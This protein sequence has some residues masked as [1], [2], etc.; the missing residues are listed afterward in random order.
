LWGC[1]FNILRYR[2]DSTANSPLAA[3]SPDVLPAVADKTF[4][5]IPVNR[6]LTF[7]FLLASTFVQ[8]MV[9][10]A[11]SQA[12]IDLRQASLEDLMDITVTSVSK[13]EEKLSKTAAAAFVITQEDIRRSGATNIPDLLRMAPGVDVEQIDANA[14]AISIRGFNSRF[15]DKVLVLIDG[16]TVYNPIFSGVQWDQIGVPLDNIERIEVIRGPGGTVWGANAVNGV[17]S[18]ITKS[19]RDTKGGQLTAAGGSEM[20]ASSQLQYGGALGQNEA[21]RIFGDYSNIGNSAAQGGGSA[22]DRWQ[23]MDTGF[24]SDWDFSKADSL[25]AQG[26]LFANLA[27]QTISSSYLSTAAGLPQTVDSAGGD[28]LA[29]WNHTLA[30]GSQTSV[31]AHYN[32]YRRDDSGIPLKVTTF[33]LDIQHH[34]A[35]GDRQDVVWGFGYRAD[36]VGAPPGYATS[37]TPPFRTVSLFNAFLQDEI[38]ISSSL[39]FTIGAKLEH[40]SYTGFETEPSARLVWSPPGGRYTIWAAASKAIRQPSRTDVDAQVDLET[41]PL[42]ADSLEVIRLLGNPLVKAEELRDYELG[43]RSELTKTLSLDAASFLSFYHHLE[44]IEPQAPIV[45]PGSPVVIEI[46]LLYENLAHAMT[47]GGELA[48]SWKASP[49]WRIAPG[50]SYLHAMLRQDPTSQGQ[51]TSAL[52][53]DFPQNMFQVRSLWTLSRKMEFDQSLYYTARLPGGSIPGHARVD[54]RLSRHLGESTE[55]SVVGQNLLRARTLEYGDA[56]GLIGTEFI[57]SFYGKITWRF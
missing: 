12:P 42:N 1:S 7:S 48:L 27:N 44:T 36:D 53:T 32:T 52:M 50:Y 10:Q 35:V 46:P 30:G 57:R 11:Q 37:F 16:R 45:I 38:R 18:I 3:G 55:I 19:S 21:Y 25:M 22:N 40:N 4:V 23:R 54:L 39:W 24:R 29:R 9:G 56:S 14:W 2:G 51:A 28:F 13:K 15:S 43:Y 41:V 20:R 34:A 49:R 31:Q 26:G 6:K 17:I 8:N 33:D 47:W 5:R